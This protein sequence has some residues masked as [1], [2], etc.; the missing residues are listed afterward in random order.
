MKRQIIFL[1]TL[2][3]LT[4]LSFAGFAQQQTHWPKIIQGEGSRTA[5][6]SPKAESFNNNIFTAHADV[7]V[8]SADD[9][10][11]VFGTIWFTGIMSSNFGKNLV[12]METMDITDVRI[13]DLTDTVRIIRLKAMLEK[14]L[15]ASGVVFSRDTLISQIALFNRESTGQEGLQTTP[16]K[17]IYAEVPTILVVLD[18]EP[19][20][21]PIENTG[22]K[23]VVNTPYVMVFSEADNKYFL[24]A[25]QYWFVA[26]QVTGQWLKTD[27][28]PS[29]VSVLDKKMKAE[30]EKTD[31]GPETLDFASVPVIMV[32]TQ[33]TELIQT[34]GPADL[35]PVEGTTLW[36]ASNTKD[37]IFK[38]PQS[39]F[40]YVL[41]TGRW[42][43]GKS[44]SGPWNFVPSDQLPREFSNIPEGWEKDN[45]RSS[46]AGTPE[47]VDAV[48]NAEVPQTAKVDRRN[49]TAT[50]D[51]DGDP[52][53]Q[54]VSGVKNTYYAS[55]TS[56]SVLRIGNVY[57]CVDNGIWYVA[58]G[59]NG[60]WQV[61]TDRPGEVDEIPADCP[62]YNVRYV[63]IYDVTP[64]YVY[65]GYTPGYTGC[66]VYGHTV[67]YGT[68]YY[69]SPWYR[70]VYF[71]RPFTWGFSMTYDPWSGWCFGSYNYWMG[72]SQG[73]YD[74]YYSHHRHGG[75]WGPPRYHPPAYHPR[76]GF[77]GHKEVG[78]LTR[79]DNRGSVKPGGLYNGRKDVTN[80]G[81]NSQYTTSAIREIKPGARPAI[82]PGNQQNITPGNNGNNRISPSGKPIQNQ[83]GSS[84]ERIKPGNQQNVN[85]GN[86][87]NR[88]SPSG[89]PIQ[90]QGGSTIEKTRPGNQQYIRPGNNNNQISPN[91]KP[92]VNP[93]GSSNEKIRPD[94][95]QNVRPAPR[96]VA[97]PNN[98]QQ[99]RP[100]VRPYGQP[101]GKPALNQP[102][103]KPVAKPQK[104]QKEN[105]G[106]KSENQ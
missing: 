95:Q 72:Y 12:S 35:Q 104:D 77:D 85:P 81:R 67:V 44:L 54:P 83:G 57:Y 58:N 42:Y 34:S 50:V 22:L 87:D 30:A 56:S 92:I 21:E 10:D 41:L 103:N 88:I 31:N 5:V 80:I 28:L 39:G 43:A 69:Y 82:R 74:G 90:N 55:N 79:T 76:P 96:P 101:A 40:Y 94:N 37:N 60:P 4:G 38:D 51:Y 91:G 32:S 97:Q 71:P 61:A 84:N 106:R 68:G 102:G 53:F 99:P 29:Q 24:K 45:V 93:G 1:N 98:Q 65:V 33:P 11:P 62:L 16:P 89:K 46:V 19:K 2:L 25:G 75:W 3:F 52:D 70:Q 105:P 20:L 64:D 36:Y 49:A 27:R 100:M 63:N 6:Y 26:G 86:H 78:H 48:R 15:P 17:I 73:Y 59:P 14:E 8:R 23:R 47:S 13:P 7:S 9:P 66:Y 18:G